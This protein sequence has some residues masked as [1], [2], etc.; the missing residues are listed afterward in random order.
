[1]ATSTAMYKAGSASSSSS[2]SSSN[3]GGSSNSMK[4]FNV[5]MFSL[6]KV[7]LK[8]DDKDKTLTPSIA[9]R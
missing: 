1:M 4:K 3:A 6:N 5:P 8:A 9:K 7:V 2:S